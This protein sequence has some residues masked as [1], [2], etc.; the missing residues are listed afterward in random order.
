MRRNRTFSIQ[1]YSGAAAGAMRWGSGHQEDRTQHDGD[2]DPKRTAH[3][4]GQANFDHR[5]TNH[6]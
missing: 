3:E 2:H 6:V 1:G 4:G 5:Q